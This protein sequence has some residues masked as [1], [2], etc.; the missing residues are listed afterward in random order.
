MTNQEFAEECRHRRI[1][2][3]TLFQPRVTP[4]WIKRFEEQ[5]LEECRASD[6]N[7]TCRHRK[8]LNAESRSWMQS[9]RGHERVSRLHIR[10][11][12]LHRDVDSHAHPDLGDIPVTRS[13]SD[14]E[15]AILNQDGP[16]DDPPPW[17]VLAERRYRARKA[18]ECD[19]CLGTCFAQHIRAGEAYT[20][21]C[22]IEDGEFRVLR[23]CEG[24]HA[25]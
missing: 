2:Y 24:A 9:G 4:E 16:E 21:L 11:A 17:R 10:T 25:P 1:S 22:V 15:R 19:A 13:L 7:S 14:G 3:D 18:H 23:L 8:S 20:V 6:L 12:G 5:V